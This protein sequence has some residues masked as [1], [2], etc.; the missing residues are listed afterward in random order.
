MELIQFLHAL[1]QQ[2]YPEE[3][4]MELYLEKCSSLQET[5]DVVRRK[6]VDTDKIKLTP[7]ID[8]ALR[9]VKY[10]RQCYQGGID[11]WILLIRIFS[12]DKKI[13]SMRHL[14]G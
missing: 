14:M 1:Y 4:L 13:R 2:P 10:R 3:R 12:K 9:M 8:S 11:N 6:Y 7:Y 5:E